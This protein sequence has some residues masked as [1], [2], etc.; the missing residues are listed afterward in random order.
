MT[1]LIDWAWPSANLKSLIQARAAIASPRTVLVQELRNQ[2]QGL[3]SAG[4]VMENIAALEAPE[5][6]AITTGHQVCLMGGPLFTLYKIATAIAMARD[7]GVRYPQYR[8]VPMLWM[9]TEDHDSEEVNH[10][11]HGFEEK[12]VY[13]GEFVGPVGR[14]VMQASIAD[15]LPESIP[16]ALQAFYAEGATMAEAFRGL[17][18]HLFGQFGLVI[19]DPDRAVLKQ[20]F[21]NI[22]ARELEGTGVAT[23]VRATTAHLESLGFKAQIFPRDINLFY[24]G[25]GNRRLIDRN[26]SGFKL[27]DGDKSWSKEE[28]LAEVQAHPEHF[29]PNVA[30]RPAYQ[31][32]LLPNLAYIGGWAEVGYWMQ[33]RDG[34]RASG[35]FYPM[36]VPRL[37]ATLV[38]APQ[39][40]AWEALGLP[41]QALAQPLHILNDQ[42]LMQNWDD[43][44]LEATIADVDAAFVALASLVE[45]IDPTQATGVRAEQTR[46]SN[47]FDNLR[48]KLRKSIRNRNPQPYQAIANL[49]NAIEPEQAQQQRTLNFTAFQSIDPLTLA[50]II[51]NSAVWSQ[52]TTQWITLP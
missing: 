40:Q 3:P 36:V 35:V 14:H 9:A 47:A 26:E 33:L 32:A 24:I 28:I 37:H 46:S 17:M 12:I 16:A 49:K 8:F 45:A 13:P 29:S 7:L 11:F 19:V 34:M 4:K 6:F 38:D 18:H 15:V 52:P 30:L 2:N 20:Q 50:Q 5:T 10:F 21:A 25:D 41:I 44:P 27:K 22:M 42:Y 48:K 39:A 43:K 31:E 51:V 23:P 1:P